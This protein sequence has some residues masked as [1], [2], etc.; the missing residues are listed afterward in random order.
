[1]ASW[2][3]LDV[4]GGDVRDNRLAQQRATEEAQDANNVVLYEQALRCQQRQQSLQAKT[5]YLQLLKGDFRLSRRLQYLCYKNLA[6]MTFEAQSFEDA[7]EYFASALALDATDV[8]VWYQMAT[9]AVETGKLWLA[10]RLLEEGIKVDAKYWPLVET[11]ALVLHHVGD[12]DAYEHVAKYIGKQDPQCTSVHLID[13]MTTLSKMRLRSKMKPLSRMKRSCNRRPVLKTVREEKLLK[14]ARKRLRHFQEIE[15]REK[16]RRKQMQKEK[17]DE[18]KSRWRVRRYILLQASWTELGKLLLE[19]FEDINRDDEVDVMRTQVQIQVGYDEETETREKREDEKVEVDQTSDHLPP[20]K[21]EKV[22]ELLKLSPDLETVLMNG[23]SDNDTQDSSGHAREEMKSQ[24]RRRKSR[25]HEER[26]RE[27]HAAAVKK[28][29][30]QDLAYQLGAFLP[31]NVGNENMKTTLTL[32]SMEWPPP[33]NVELADDEFSISNESNEILL[34]TASFPFATATDVSTSI[35]EPSSSQLLSSDQAVH[36]MAPRAECVTKRQI[37]SFISE[38]G[39]DGG[40]MDWIRLYLNQCGHWSNLKLGSEAE[41]IH[42]VCMWLEKTLNGDL[43]ATKAVTFTQ[44]SVIN[45]A[46]HS[47][48]QGSRFTGNGLS[49]GAQ[50]FLLELHFDALLQ[51]PVRGKMQCKIRSQVE[52]QLS[53]AQNL[54]FSFGWLENSEDALCRPTGDE[55]LRLFWLMARMYE[56]CGEHQ[57]ARYYFTKCREKLQG[58]NE[59]DDQNSKCNCRVDLIN[60]K[61]DGE[62]TLGILDEKI[63]GL[64]YSDVCAEARRL[65]ESGDHDHVV[66]VLLGHFFPCKQVP[67]MRDFLN[68]FEVDEDKRS[69][70]GES[71]IFFEM[72]LHSLGQSSKFSDEDTTLFLLT[73]LYYVIDFLDGLAV[74]KEPTSSENSS[75]EACTNALA[76][77]IFLLARLTQKQS[78][79]LTNPDHR[80]MLRGL[81]VKCLQPSILFCFDSPNNVLSMI[82]VVLETD[83]DNT[84]GLCDD[85][86][87]SQRMIG[88]DAMARLLY[89]VRSLP[90]EEYRK[91]FTLVPHAAKKKPPRRDRIRVIIVE[92]LR[93][94]NRAFRDHGEAAL[95]YPLPKRFALMALC[96]ILVKEEE[97][98]V[99]QSDGKTPR[100]LFGNGAVLFLQLYASSSLPDPSTMPIQLVELISLLHHRL[101]KH[102]ICGLTYFSDTGFAA[103]SRKI[104]C[105]L[106]ASTVL[107]SKYVQ[108]E[109][110]WDEEKLTKKSDEESYEEA[111]KEEGAK[112]GKYLFQMEACQC[113]RCLYDVQILP[114]CEDHKTGATFA[115]LQD[116]NLSTNYEDAM[117]LIRFAVPILLTTKAKNNSQKKERL[118]L[119]YAVR[120]ALSG[121]SYFALSAQPAAVSTLLEAYL[122]PRGLLQEEIA[123]PLPSDANDTTTES[124][125]KVC[126]GHMWYLM[127]A[128]YILGR[129]KRRGNLVELMELEQHI[130]ERVQFLMKDVLYYHPD[131]V[132]SWVRLGKT[133]KELYHA[134]TDAFAAVLGRKLRV[135][136]FQWYTTKI[137]AMNPERSRKEQAYS[138]LDMFSFQN[139]VLE[140]NLFKKMK[141]WQGKNVD[142]NK[143]GS[144]ASKLK[145]C[146]DETEENDA[147]FETLRSQVSIEEYA[148]IYIAQVIE[149]TRRCFDMAAQ[150]AEE[151]VKKHNLK[152]QGKRDNADKS[153]DK[154]ANTFDKELDDLQNKIIE[155]NEECGL[156]LF[157]VLQ[158]FSL[159]KETNLALFPHEMYSRLINDTLA[160]F[161]RGWTVCESKEDAHE[162]HFRLQYMIGKTLRKRR[163]CELRKH[164]RSDPEA[165]STATEIADSFSRAESARGEGDREHALVHAFYA[166]QA[167]RI[168][169]TIS[170]SSSV[171]ALRLVCRHFYE[172]EKQAVGGKGDDDESFDFVSTKEVDGQKNAQ[173]DDDGI[174]ASLKSD[175]VR[176]CVSAAK[177]DDILALLAAADRNDSIRELNVTLARG[178]LA[179]NIIM[180]L[181]S[182]PDED[183]YFHPS[184]YVLARIVYW[185]STFYSTLEQSG[186]TCDSV[187]ALV[188]A[189]RAHRGEEQLQGP[190]VAAARA[191]KKMAP[192]FDKRRPQIVAI[193]FS[194]YIPPAKRYEELNQRQMKYDY[195]RLKY[196]RFY[197]A[198]LQENAAYG[199][200]K[201]AGSW[202]LACKEDHDV[203]DIMLSIVLRARGKVLASQFQEIL[204]TLEGAGGIGGSGDD[205]STQTQL[206][207][208]SRSVDGLF[209]QLAR[210]YTYYL[211]VFHAQHRLTHAIDDYE[212][213]LENAELPMVAV[214]LV[215][216]TKYPSEMMVL[217]KDAVILDGIF[218]ANVTIIKEALR[219]DDLRPGIYDAQGQDAWKAYT[220]AAHSFCEERWP[221]RS[222]KEGKLFKKSS[223]PKANAAATAAAVTFVLTN[224]T[225]V[226]Q[227]T[228]N[229]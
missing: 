219:R 115:S 35:T 108:K 32:V 26:L 225:D 60:Q 59:D 19:A 6:T 73:T 76:A 71:T 211:E 126:L 17:E 51:Q 125:D 72:V 4:C 192:I 167:L 45:V 29:R 30:E 148:T 132:D 147:R 158:E 53:K 161:R 97:E 63:S 154:E 50:L 214:F 180:A 133:M 5:G 105:F 210:T 16:K 156:L 49:L 79:H 18:S 102:G 10:R 222:G 2:V 228:T 188:D 27:E 52:I 138:N 169:L 62:I 193:W 170:D 172:E 116:G 212:S 41:V 224:T 82:R 88:V 58:L 118:K 176:K 68:E 204:D 8:V 185:L 127:G 190:S 205:A 87:R 64:H 54:L 184:R 163:W 25:R 78:E 119:L 178:W 168:K 55:F 28:A 199:K 9:T 40:I 194:E 215:G 151:A 221:E 142:E 48:I 182:I 152:R 157:N 189:V 86:D 124:P 15:E 117:R 1:M 84:H 83:N 177:K 165:L 101:G 36:V 137:L 33:L 75:D 217:E 20:I 61:A 100:Q 113:Y 197:I 140:W 44:R 229:G 200:L 216:V 218:H 130:R 11:L 220:C 121:S 166:L 134:A 95:S 144:K 12:K 191:L 203:I 196:W 39:G 94:L 111:D 104:S 174:C 74:E 213:L 65:F 103:D 23:I 43:D 98:I 187:M 14:R 122:A 209:K 42:K 92:L 22:K 89:I 135:R 21:I 106:E 114:G 183:R 153:V 93:F 128:N 164:E 31:M 34:K 69:G 96:S 77:L 81:C 56:R 109:S 202:V 198:L 131:R 112:E 181:E 162:A 70:R 145:G 91:L 146:N 201:E 24:P 136:A 155:C 150:L 107:L 3:A 13:K 173:K 179:L 47:L 207:G 226:R 90:G 149:F 186:Y 123:L 37:S 141:E 143:V 139:V 223:R 160:Y 85:G 120:D 67:R 7:L 66:S 110:I 227:S 129:A 57:M 195:Y 208:E 206:H 80:L 99:A 38:R 175:A 159:M 46:D 171:S